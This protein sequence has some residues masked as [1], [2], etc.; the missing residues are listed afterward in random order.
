MFIVIY[1]TLNYKY[2]IYFRPKDGKC[3]ALYLRPKKCYGNGTVWY[4]DAPV[5]VHKLQT[6][7]GRMCTEIGLKGHYTNHSLRATCATRL[8]RNN[9][10]D[11]LVKS[12]TRHRS[13]ALWDYKRTSEEQLQSVSDSLNNKKPRIET[14]TTA[15]PKSD[16]DNFEQKANKQ[17]KEINID[18][19][20][21]KIS[22]K[23]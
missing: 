19:G 5:G 1:D 10:Q 23:F 12:K 22:L 20:G 11:Q 15:C 3:N 9:V 14:T 13:N 2:L 17:E 8:Y 18:A 7:I 16:S 6:T 4:D 21:I